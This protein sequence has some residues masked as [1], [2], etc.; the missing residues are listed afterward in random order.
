MATTPVTVDKNVTIPPAVLAAAARANELQKQVYGTTEAEVTP[1]GNPPE[2]A[3]AHIPVES[4]PA[5][6]AAQPAAPTPAPEPDDD[7][8]EKR[9]K[10]MKGRYDKEVPRLKEQVDT[11]IG[12]VNNLRG[13]LG[14]LE[15][16]S[17]EPAQQPAKQPK[18]LITAEQ[19][20]DYGAE[21]F[22]VVEMK[23]RELIEPLQE[24]Y[25]NSLKELKQQINGVNTQVAQTAT[26]RM[27]Q[28]LDRDV[29]TWRAV[30][31]DWENNGFK[32]WL[33][34]PDPYSGDIRHSLLNK[35]Y[36]RFDAPRVAAFFKGF[37][38]EV[39]A[40]APEGGADPSLAPTTPVAPKVPLASFAAPGRAKTAAPS[41]PAEK[42]IITRR[43]IHQYYQ[44]INAGRYKGRDAERAE[45]ER[46]IFEAQRE[47]RIVD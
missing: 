36:E 29:P 9:Y 11:L 37:H 30:N 13:V 21:F 2:P 32:E 7:N 16:R 31:A 14:T 33:Q 17:P 47:G 45:H 39:A 46:M 40:T 42:P 27:E 5:T 8:W 10:A 38:A 4:V 22:Q 3:P 41:L 23:A 25:E 34:L 15:A 19:E 24:Q 44:D 1:E 6:P 26:V 12:E 20:Q 35:A 18:K 43:Q 28:Q